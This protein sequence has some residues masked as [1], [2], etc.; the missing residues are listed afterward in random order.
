VLDRLLTNELS[1]AM[2]AQLATALGMT[3]LPPRTISTNTPPF[4]EETQ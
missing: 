3:N 2:A 4:S 1:P